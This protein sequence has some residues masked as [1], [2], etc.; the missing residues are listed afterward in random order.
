MRDQDK[1]QPPV[2]THRD[3][4]V[5]AKIWRNHS[6]EGEA[7]YSVTFQRTFTD[8]ATQQPREAHSFQGTDILKVQQLASEAYQTVGRLREQDRIPS[9]EREQAE[10]NLAQQRDAAMQ[11]AAPVQRSAPRQRTRER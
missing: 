7:F 3:G 1:S 10:P 11:E 6:N 4:A 9:Y 2:E 5:S 8:P